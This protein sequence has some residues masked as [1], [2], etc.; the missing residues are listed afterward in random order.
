MGDANVGRI[1]AEIEGTPADSDIKITGLRSKLIGQ[2]STIRNEIK[3]LQVGYRGKK[4]FTR[5]MN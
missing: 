2:I 5:T 4:L 3:K 1:L